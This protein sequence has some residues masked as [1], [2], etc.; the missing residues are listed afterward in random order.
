VRDVAT[1]DFLLNLLDAE[2]GSEE[3]ACTVD[4]T[5]YAARATPKPNKA[6]CG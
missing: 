4:R 1:R 3:A 5:L 2:L 6:A